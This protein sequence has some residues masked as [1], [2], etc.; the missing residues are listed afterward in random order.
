MFFTLFIIL[1]F[2]Y[3]IQGEGEGK[4]P[5]LNH[6]TLLATNNDEETN[7]DC[8]KVLN[9]G[10]FNGNKINEDF[11]KSLIKECDKYL[12]EESN[13]LYFNYCIRTISKSIALSTNIKEVKKLCNEQKVKIS[14]KKEQEDFILVCLHPIEKNTLSKC[15]YLPEEIY[16]KN[17]ERYNCIMENARRDKDENYCNFLKGDEKNDCLLYLIKN[18][19]DEEFCGRLG[20]NVEICNTINYQEICYSEIGYKKP[21]KDNSDATDINSIVPIE[22]NNETSENIT[23]SDQNVE[24]YE[25]KGLFSKTF[26]WLK[27]II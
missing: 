11:L 27:K 2:V 24:E 22:F 20:G 10:L 25:K 3:A 23:D 16:E 19:K 1:P 9:K 12:L 6:N 7:K 14:G 21:D 8:I 5:E 26:R 15:I 4:C 17:L 13:E 18:L